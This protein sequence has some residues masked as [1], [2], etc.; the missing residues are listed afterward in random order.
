MDELLLSAA[1][2]DAAEL[3]SKLLVVQSFELKLEHLLPKISTVLAK[4][5]STIGLLELLSDQLYAQCTDF[6]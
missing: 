5:N 3:L 1:V 2:R 6:I 4:A